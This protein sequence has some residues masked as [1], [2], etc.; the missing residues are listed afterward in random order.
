MI[1]H[2][3]AWRAPRQGEEGR[4]APRASTREGLTC[5][6]SLAG[7]G[8]RD[9]HPGGLALEGHPLH[10]ASHPGHSGWGEAGGA[11][12]KPTQGAHTPSFPPPPPSQG[13]GRSGAGVTARTASAFRKLLMRSHSAHWLPLP[14]RAESGINLSF[15]GGRE[16]GDLRVGSALLLSPPGLRECPR[17]RAHR[18][19]SL[20][21]GA[22]VWLAPR[23][24][25]H[26]TPAPAQEC[27]AGLPS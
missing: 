24:H 16:T 6:R 5:C 17:T 18:D 8:P 4:P 13:S 12:G 15:P 2:Q 21:P 20:G 23:H 26:P 7:V 10:A 22:H 3:E 14:I 25:A 1:F 19:R 11:A 27:W 9:P